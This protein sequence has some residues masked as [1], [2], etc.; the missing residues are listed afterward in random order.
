MGMGAWPDSRVVRPSDSADFPQKG[1][2]VFDDETYLE[3]RLG[4][5]LDGNLHSFFAAHL[6]GFRQNNRCSDRGT[7]LTQNELFLVRKVTFSQKKFTIV[8]SRSR[9]CKKQFEKSVITF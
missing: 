6:F 7:F 9:I 4:I 1:K 5:I 3:K 2:T 8:G